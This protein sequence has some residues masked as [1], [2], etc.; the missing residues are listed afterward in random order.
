MVIGASKYHGMSVFIECLSC[1]RDKASQ[2]YEAGFEASFWIRNYPP[3]LIIL[4]EKKCNDIK[5][6]RLIGM[7]VEAGCSKAH[8]HL[9]KIIEKSPHFGN[10]DEA[11]EHY[12]LAANRG[13]PQ[14]LRQ[15]AILMMNSRPAKALQ[16]LKWSADQGD[17]LAQFN[18]ASCLAVGR[19][20]DA[21]LEAA[22]KYY[23]YSA[24]QGYKEARQKLANVKSNS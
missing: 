1:S 14:A 23:E 11:M 2:K 13:N 24:A 20:I 22:R 12:Q 19:G 10:R 21:D 4:A 16:L 6:A 7:A 15:L 8:Y 5:S 17:A 18:L 3:A 9:G